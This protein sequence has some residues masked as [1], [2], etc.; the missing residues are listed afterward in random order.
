M[1]KTEQFLAEKEIDKRQRE[2]E[3]RKKYLAA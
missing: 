1:K 3:L 2:V